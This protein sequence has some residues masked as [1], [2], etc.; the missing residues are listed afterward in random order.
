MTLLPQDLAS[1]LERRIAELERAQHAQGEENLRL[2]HELAIARDWQRAAAEILATIAASS[3][4]ADQALRQIA[5][6][7]VRL[8]NAAS[9]TLRIVGN[10]AAADPWSQTLAVGPGG[11]R[12]AAAVANSDLKIGGRN[13]PGTVVAEN[14]QIHLP[15]IFNVEP[16]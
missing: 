14:R 9:V 10:P 3:G 6:T 12:I 1:D 13:F 11:Q 4:D 15:D 7:T 2:R 8:F 16:A 5:D